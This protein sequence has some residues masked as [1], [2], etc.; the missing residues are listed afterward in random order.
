MSGNKKSSDD[1]SRSVSMKKLIAWTILSAFVSFTGFLGVF[2]P[3]SGFR[4]ADIEFGQSTGSLG[5]QLI[6]SN[7]FG[8][9]FLRGLYLIRKKRKADNEKKSQ[10][11]MPS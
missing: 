10:N 9:F 11:G 3:G 7:F 4:A 6:G 8:L 5:T 2:V 1:T